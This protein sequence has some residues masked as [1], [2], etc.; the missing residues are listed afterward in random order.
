MIILRNKYSIIKNYTIYGERC[1]GTNF[2]ENCISNTFDIPVVWDYGWKHFFG[3]CHFTK[4]LEAKN[5]L[6]IGIVRNPFN[7]IQSL[8]NNPYH[9]PQKLYSNIDKFITDQWYSVGDYQKEN[10]QDRNYITNERY[11]NIVD[12]R[13]HKNMYLVEYMPKMVNNLMIINY[14][15]FLTN[16]DFHMRILG[17]TF[18]LRNNGYRPE[19][20]IR[21]DY[22]TQQKHYEFIS[23]NLNWSYEHLL[24]FRKELYPKE[25]II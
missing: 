13:N 12:M 23:N 1:S 19:L 18:N 5:T 4:L 22:Y 10:P 15:D 20:K 16:Y 24:G 9:V 8:F 11:A 25:L 7:W 6:F 2:L 3:F 21:N 17:R 14:D